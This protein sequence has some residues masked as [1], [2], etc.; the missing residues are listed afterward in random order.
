VLPLRRRGPRVVSIRARPL[1]STD[2]TVTMWVNGVPLE[3][4]PA[5]PSLHEYRWTV[6]KAYWRVGMNRLQ[7]G[8]SKLARPIDRGIAHD[9]RL[10]GLAVDRI[11]VRHPDDPF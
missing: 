10:L 7:V 4:V 11:R 2:M 3:A 6:P 1:D 9:D 8:V 5:E